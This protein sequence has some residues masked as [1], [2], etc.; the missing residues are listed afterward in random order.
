MP[1]TY[2][3]LITISSTHPRACMEGSCAWWQDPGCAVSQ[4]ASNLTGITLALDGLNA[5]SGPQ[6]PNC[7]HNPKEA[8][9]ERN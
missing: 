9:N 5:A 2:C 1:N 4:I 6:Y 7:P 8:H 3:P